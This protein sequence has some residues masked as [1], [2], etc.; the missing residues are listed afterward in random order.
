MET[1]RWEALRDLFARALELP[2]GE[3]D[4]FLD[5]VCDD[6]AMR[7]EVRSLLA[8]AE[9]EGP[10][11]ALAPRLASVRDV[12]REH[13]PE[14]VGPYVIAERIGAGGMGVV[15]RAHDPRLRRDVALKFL[16]AFLH[17]HTPGTDRL[18]AEARAASTLDHPN[19]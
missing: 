10:L 14:S 18:I 3:R 11:D 8:V 4:A 17:D 12:L 1:P 13:V 16:P 2:V 19:I 5:D 15:Y 7:D 6:D 9:R